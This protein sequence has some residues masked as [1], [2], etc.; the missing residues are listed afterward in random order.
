MGCCQ[1]DEG[2]VDG[3]VGRQAGSKQVFV[4]AIGLT[5]L[6]FHPVAVYGMLEALL[7]Y[8]EQQLHC[9]ASTLAFLYYI[10]SPNRKGSL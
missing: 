1:P 7:W 9:F 10:D 6:S 2:Q 8:T 5:Q 3:L 4:V